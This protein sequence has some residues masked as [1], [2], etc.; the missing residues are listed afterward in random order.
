M[1]KEKEKIREELEQWSPRLAKLKDDPQT[2][3]QLPENYFHRLTQ[4]IMEQVSLEPKPATP[5]RPGAARP[6]RQW[7]SGLLTPRLATGLAAVA[8]LLAAALLWLRPPA[9][10]GE[11]P[12]AAEL[13]TQEM[14]DYI[15][16]HID[17]F[18]LEMLAEAAED[19][20]TMSLQRTE[21]EELD[22]YLDEIIDELELEDL[23]ELF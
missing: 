21:S 8:L 19:E 13:T 15:A 22:L 2:P 16:A 1:K 7:L 11:L 14:T 23:Q 12:A 6:W 17:D 4:E 9:G 18:E 5:P 3:F 10:P 20:G